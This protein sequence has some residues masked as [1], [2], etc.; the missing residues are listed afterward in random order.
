MAA[1]FPNV[2]ETGINIQEAQRAQT[3][4]TQTDPHQDIL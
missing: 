4:G 1:N 2:K 3:S